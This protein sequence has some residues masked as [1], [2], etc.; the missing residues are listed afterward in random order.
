[1]KTRS[2]RRW[3]FVHKWS[4]LISTIFL[5]LLC[6]TGLPLVFRGELD[7]VMNANGTAAL[8]TA[9][10]ARAQLDEI[11]ANG[12]KARPGE[13]VQFLVWDRDDPNLIILSMAKARDAAPDQNVN[14]RIDGRNGE[15]LGPNESALT[16]FFLKLHTELFAGLGGKL[17]LGSMGVLFVAALVSGV[18]LY[19]PFMRKLSFGTVRAS[20]SARLRWLDL[21]NLIGIVTVSW[22]LVVGM[23]GVVNT[24]ADLLVKVWQY[25]ELTEMVGPYR[26]SP[27]LATTVPLAQAVDAARTATPEMTPYFVAMPGSLLTSNTHFGVFMRGNTPLTSRLLKPVLVD[28][29]TGRV[30]DTRELPWYIWCLLMSQP[31][32]FGDYG[33]MPLKIIWALLDVMTII[34]LGSGLYLWLSRGRSAIE[35]RIAAAAGGALASAAE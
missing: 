15:V 7:A 17:F 2:L 30:T 6:I 12:M 9:S 13:Y 22:A 5:L 28:A 18:V 11:V 27:P 26:S 19:G 35:Q 3:A 16:E 24:W 21:H 23:T 4:S 1:M 25:T 29:A 20:G 32:H 10:D 34:V 14:V 33:G 8:T 31:L